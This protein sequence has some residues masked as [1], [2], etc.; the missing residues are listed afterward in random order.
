MKKSVLILLSI[1][2]IFLLFTGCSKLY[3][4]FNDAVS[5]RLENESGQKI[6]VAS[7]S[8]GTNDT[9][10]G[11]MSGENADGTALQDKGKECLVFPVEVGDM[12]DTKL[13]D[14]VFDFYVCTHKDSDF[15]YIG[16]VLVTS[17]MLHKTYTIKV[18][19]KDGRLILSGDEPELNIIPA[20]EREEN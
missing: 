19:E 11:S 3:Y 6:Y 14:M 15:I 9:V 8:F 17:S 7:V 18:I 5:F 20:A 16:R 13:E 12:N 4:H 2:L 10:F 1:V